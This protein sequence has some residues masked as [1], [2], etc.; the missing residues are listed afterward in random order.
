M[1]REIDHPRWNSSWAVPS[2]HTIDDLGE[3]GLL[4]VEPSHNKARTFV[5]SMEGRGRAQAVE[6]ERLNPGAASNA[7][8]PPLNRVLTWLIEA[9]AD[10]QSCFALPSR[11]LD[12]AVRAGFIGPGARESLAE[13]IIALHD[14]GYLSGMLIKALGMS[15]QQMLDQ[16]GPLELTMKSH[17]GRP[18]RRPQRPGPTPPIF[19]ELRRRPKPPPTSTEDPARSTEPAQ[20]DVFISH[21][22]EDKDEIARPL[23]DALGDAGYSVW[24]DQHELTVGDVL[25]ERIDH[26]LANSRFGIVILSSAFF[27]KGW[28]KRELSGLV[29]R[30]TASGAKT[31][32]PVWH[33]VTHAQVAQ[34]SPP[35]ADQYAVS[36]ER[37]ITAV[38]AE[39]RRALDR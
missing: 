4:R 10:E 13:R 26:G 33:R 18:G 21:A 30:Q 14:Q 16:S 25:S 28:P 23:T 31:I 20:W 19:D 8:A 34:F 6:D 1:R 12:R 5:L 11:L 35:L 24:F 29:T 36:T 9:E 22:G 17:E 27:G 37:G 32:L 38:V 2:E 3:L 39:L 7:H 15:A